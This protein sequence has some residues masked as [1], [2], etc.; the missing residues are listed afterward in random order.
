MNAFRVFFCEKSSEE[1]NDQFPV[2]QKKEGD[3]KDH[4]ADKYNAGDRVHRG[5]DNRGCGGHYFISSALHD[6]LHIPAAN[7]ECSLDPAFQVA[8]G[9]VYIV[10][11]LR[12]VIFKADD[13]VGNKIKYYDE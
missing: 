1:L 12:Q 6:L 5:I 13:G 3:D 10:H 11:H 2:Q 4:D 7:I 8:D 9:P